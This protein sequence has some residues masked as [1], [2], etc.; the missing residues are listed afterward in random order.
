MLGGRWGWRAAVD[1][2]GWGFPPEGSLEGHTAGRQV[3]AV[4][5]TRPSSERRGRSSSV[6]GGDLVHGACWLRYAARLSLHRR[7]TTGASWVE[8]K[9]ERVQG[10]RAAAY[11]PWLHRKTHLAALAVCQSS[12]TSV[13]GRPGHLHLTRECAGWHGQRAVQCRKVLYRGRS[14]S[15]VHFSLQVRRPPTS[16]GV[17][18]WGQEEQV[19][20]WLSG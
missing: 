7:C 12:S 10:I 8:L 9:W 2:D 6:I 3:G 18:S 15:T 4:H 1:T 13:G 14:V 5:S 17:V 11:G 16:V 19:G 20:G